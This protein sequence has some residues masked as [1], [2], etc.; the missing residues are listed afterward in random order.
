MKRALILNYEFPPLGGGGGIATR[1]I[2]KGLIK[3]GYEV[4]CVTTGHE[5]LTKTQDVDGIHIH[6]VYVYGRKNIETA[7]MISMLLFPLAAF[8][9]TVRLCRKYKYE[10]I[11]THF[12]IPTGPL[13]YVVSKMFGIRN[14][15]FVHGGDV[16]DPSKTSSPHRNPLLRYLI[17][18]LMNNA[19]AVVTQSKDIRDRCVEMYRFKKPIQV[20]PLPYIPKEF[21]PVTR[22][23]L[24]LSDEKRYVIGIG[25]LVKRK[26][27]NTFIQ[28]L[29]YL[30]TPV[31]GLIIGEGP[32]RDSLMKAAEH[33][34]VSNRIRFLGSLS[35][36]KKFQYLSNSDIFLLTSLHE[37][38]GIVL[39]EAM[40][41]G[42]P[43]VST[44]E[45]GQTDIIE[46]GRSGFF[47]SIKD[48]EELAWKVDS[49]LNDN[50]SRRSISEYNKE[51]IKDF[52]LDKITGQY[53]NL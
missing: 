3:K 21:A 24:G 17:T 4:D 46:E 18:F 39:Q 37:G 14:I 22:S 16:Y 38:Y 2:A 28:V 51:K 5:S 9:E 12:V 40:L 50:E 43:V 15:V 52:D 8:F 6:R 27:F 41:V 26:D 34:G 10:F 33:A 53:Q 13:G 11:H 30:D 25:R 23:D 36:E 45:G 32:E 29:S 49:L 7:S 48:A 31:E 19:D 35:E 1:T 42:L 47:A 20:I 44:N